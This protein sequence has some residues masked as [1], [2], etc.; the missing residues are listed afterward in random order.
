MVL[1]VMIGTITQQAIQTV[2]CQ[3]SN[4][5]G[6]ASLPIAHTSLKS[7]D[8][9]SAIGFFLSTD[10]K[11][12]LI[13]GLAGVGQTNSFSPI[14]PSG[15][16]AFLAS[17]GFSYSTVGIS[18]DC[19]DVSS[20]IIQSG[21][22]LDSWASD[23][24]YSD[25]AEEPPVTTYTLLNGLHL[26]YDLSPRLSAF[27]WN[28]TLAQAELRG[29]NQSGELSP[30]NLNLTDREKDLVFDS[31]W[32]DSIVFLMPTTNP[33]ENPSDYYS[34]FSQ[35]EIRAMPATKA[36]SC[37]ELNLPSVDTL[38]G[39]FSVTA[40]A[41]LFYISLQRY[42]SSVVNGVLEEKLLQNSVP[43]P[44]IHQ[45]IV[46]DQAQSCW[47]CTFVDPCVIEG[48]VYTN[49]SANLSS[50]PGG[51][52]MVGNT[53][54]PLRCLYGLDYPWYRALTA[55]MEL[56]TTIGNKNYDNRCFQVGNYTSMNCAGTWWLNPMFNGGNA[57]IDSIREVMKRGFDSLSAQLR[58]NG[59][60]WDGNPTN[61]SGI[62]YDTVVCVVFRWEWLFYP[63]GLVVGA[64]VLLLL[65]LASN[66][67]TAK[68]RKHAIWKSSVL[69]FLFYGLEDRIRD[70][71]SR[72]APQEELEG[73]AKTLSTSFSPGDDG[74]R[75]HN[76]N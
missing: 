61:V 72:L 21:R 42:E 41:C 36:N 71:A 44:S 4:P 38:P 63:L 25:L 19:I 51:T 65:L 5:N 1:S 16:C 2:S 64:S 14:C 23:Q 52:T 7:V 3:R 76:Q 56:S 17:D 70:Q 8:S 13:A 20:L 57:S 35:S 22:E 59:T 67:G 49:T 11:A 45:D 15:N 29:L 60:D 39:Y 30:Q 33:C 68:S 53:T 24:N 26:G 46:T 58:M 40:A 54:V 18:S 50:V 75:F 74:W 12:S 27:R 32:F 9:T 66:L 69:P 47:R 6:V 10:L 48:V 31:P 28:T 34:Y 43:F 55:Q 37:P 62:A 73:M